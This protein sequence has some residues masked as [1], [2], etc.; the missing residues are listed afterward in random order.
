M[1]YGFD[2]DGTLDRKAVLFLAKQLS[3]LGHEIHVIS[4]VF[5]EAGDWQHYD[6]KLKKLER[7]WKEKLSGNITLHVIESYPSEGDRDLRLVNI[8]LKKGVL[9][10]QLGLEIMFDDSETYTKV[11]KSMAGDLVVMHVK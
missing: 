2:L 7:L 6:E 1:K 10:E 3:Y 8:G 4:G 9:A 11:M 5:K